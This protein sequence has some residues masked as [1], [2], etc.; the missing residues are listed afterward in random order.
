MSVPLLSVPS[1]NGS[2]WLYLW[3]RTSERHFAAQEI[4]VPKQGTPLPR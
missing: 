4:T 2:G 1:E 3:D